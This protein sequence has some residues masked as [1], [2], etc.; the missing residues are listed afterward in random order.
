MVFWVF[1][2]VNYV[3]AALMYS[4]L[5]RFILSF[6]MVPD[7]ANYIYRFFVRITDPVLRMVRFVTP[8]AVPQLL[9]VVLSAV[10][11]LLLRF[12][13]LVGAAQLLG[14]AAPVAG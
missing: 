1:A 11:L 7:S 10:W 9:L 8:L 2:A 6:F 3:L 12:A 4:L 13:L 5:A 14:G